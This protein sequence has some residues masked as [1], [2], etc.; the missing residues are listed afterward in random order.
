MKK[1]FL[2]LFIALFFQAHGF[3]FKNKEKPVLILS[4][5][6]PTVIQSFDEEIEQHSV[7]QKNTRIYFLVHVP[8]GFKSNYIRYQIIKQNDNAHEGG[9]SRWRAKNVR[10]KDKYTYSDYFTL[11]QAGKYYLQI[12]D[13]EN[14]HQWRAIGAFRV[15]DE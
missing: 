15:V 4:S 11:S 8:E 6:N 14:L 12:F 10:I 9:Y 7:F 1:I 5:K 3:L 2:T 13:I